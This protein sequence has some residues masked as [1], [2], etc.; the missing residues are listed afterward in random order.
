MTSIKAGNVNESEYSINH[1]KSADKYRKRCQKLGQKRKT[2][3]ADKGNSLY[4]IN[5]ESI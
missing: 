5:V 3:P 4:K 1:K 2:K